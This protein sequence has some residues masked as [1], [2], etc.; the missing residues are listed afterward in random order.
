[1]M[2]KILVAASTEPRT[3]TLLPGDP[4]PLLLSDGEMLGDLPELPG[5]RCPVAEFFV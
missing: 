1:M 5:F 3:K 4:T 2:G